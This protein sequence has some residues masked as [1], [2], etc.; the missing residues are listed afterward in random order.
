MYFILSLGISL[1]VMI[2]GYC[3]WANKIAE[4]DTLDALAE[5][6]L[7]DIM[8]NTAALVTASVAFHSNGKFNKF[9]P[10]VNIFCYFF[11]YSYCRWL[12]H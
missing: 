11:L 4:S 7:N 2:Y 10:V 12:V 8:S 5:D 6:H 3:Y 9:L 1:K